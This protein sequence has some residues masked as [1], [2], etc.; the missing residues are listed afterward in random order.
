MK[1]QALEAGGLGCVLVAGA[2]EEGTLGSRAGPVVLLVRG[3]ALTCRCSAAD[4][5][6]DHNAGD[7]GLGLRSTFKPLSTASVA[8]VHV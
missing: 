4:L 7:L 1:A 8:I 6:Y 3:K 5:W 2:K